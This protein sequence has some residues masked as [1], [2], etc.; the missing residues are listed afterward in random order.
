MGETDGERLG[1]HHARDQPGIQK[2]APDNHQA[3]TMSISSTDYLVKA[4]LGGSYKD[5]HLLDA[6]MDTG[7]V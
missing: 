4:S 3:P 1:R 2:D 5:M 7:A 6:I